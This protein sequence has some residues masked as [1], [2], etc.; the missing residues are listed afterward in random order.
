[1]EM[2][3]PAPAAAVSD[4]GGGAD[5]PAWPS[6]AACLWLALCAFQARAA[7]A[8]SRVVGGRLQLPPAERWV[9]AWLLY[10]AVVH[11][12]LE[13]PFVCISLVSSVAESDSVHSMLW[14]EYGRADSRWL[15]S[16]PT[17]VA[18]EILMV[19]VAGPLALLLVFAIVQD[20]H[21]C[22]SVQVCLCVCELYGGW[23]TSAP[24]WLA[25]S[26]SL[27]SD[28]ADLLW[29][30]LVF[31]DGLWVL[32]PIVLLAQSWGALAVA[33]RPHVAKAAGDGGGGKR[34]WR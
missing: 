24:E 20:K 18:L 30:Y 2:P 5:D 12:T 1:M 7:L 4:A 22:H 3:S 15:H 6:R 33:H 29:L 9:V 26:A 13:G 32:L 21:Y 28:S 17:V 23:M 8:V 31:F 11:I 14:K 16:D 27:R 19:A 25:G 34:K 10:D